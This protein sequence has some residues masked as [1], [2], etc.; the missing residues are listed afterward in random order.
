[1]RVVAAGK[2]FVRA[3]AQ[4]RLFWLDQST[5]G[6][7]RQNEQNRD[8][9]ARLCL[10]FHRPNVCAL[11]YIVGT[12]TQVF[13][14]SR[15]C[16]SPTPIGGFRQLRWTRSLEFWNGASRHDFD[17][18]DIAITERSMKKVI[19]MSALAFVLAVGA[20]QVSFAQAGGGG[21]GAGGAGGGSSGAGGAWG[22]RCGWKYRHGRRIRDG[23][24]DRRRRCWQ[25]GYG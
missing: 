4:G 10:G 9:T 17:I 20:A 2:R 1:M 11:W 25:H 18:R 23:R 22:Y 16:D 21:G 8:L 15:D 5:L 7:P 24:H 12:H 3:K 13:L 19:V 6:N 14:P